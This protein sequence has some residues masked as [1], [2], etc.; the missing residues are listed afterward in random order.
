MQKKDKTWRLCIDYK[1]LNK[2]AI[3][4]RY[5]IPMIDDLIDQLKGEKFFSKIGLNSGYH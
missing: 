5:P 3:K 2:I 4:N 1:Y